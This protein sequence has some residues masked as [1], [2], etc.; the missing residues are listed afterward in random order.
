MYIIIIGCYS[1][2]DDYIRCSE[3][4]N[5]KLKMVK[6][7][8]LS[9]LSNT[10][11]V[12]EED[13]IERPSKRRRKEVE[14]VE[15]NFN[16]N[17]FCGLMNGVGLKNLATH[18]VFNIFD[19]DGDGSINMKEFLLALIALRSRHSGEE[20]MAAAELYFSIFDVDEDGYVTRDEMV[21]VS[22]LPFQLFYWNH[23]LLYV[24]NGCSLLTSRW[25]RTIVQRCSA[26]T[27]CG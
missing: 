11:A 3:E 19:I 25:G 6:D 17:D 1:D 9:K 24:G 2:V 15:V 7:S 20:E 23:P 13:K 26:Q 21:C 10:A 16:F 8:L 5:A 4:Y 12:G 14:N 18:S 22:V 27:R